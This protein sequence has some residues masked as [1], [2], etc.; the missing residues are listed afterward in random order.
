MGRSAYLPIDSKSGSGLI[1][2]P[3][4]QGR[5]W[6]SGSLASVNEHFALLLML[7]CSS[8]ALCDVSMYQCQ[9]FTIQ[10]RFERRAV[11]RHGA[12]YLLLTMARGASRIHFE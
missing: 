6:R 11:S 2:G 3:L 8:T 1:I 12:R 9:C 4:A 10:T 7:G 5:I